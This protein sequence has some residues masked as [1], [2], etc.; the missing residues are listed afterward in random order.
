MGKLKLDCL[1]KV[2]LDNMESRLLGIMARGL[3][4]DMGQDIDLMEKTKCLHTHQMS[5]ATVC[6][7]S[8][9]IIHL[10]GMLG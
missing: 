9:E 8:R 10:Q 4:Q 7:R 6:Q 1:I 2:G 3:G 5:I